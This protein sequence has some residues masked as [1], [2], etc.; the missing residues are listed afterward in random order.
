MTSLTAVGPAAAGQHGGVAFTTTHWSVVL[1]AQGESPA[2]QEALE[3]LCRIYWRPIYSFLRRQGISADDAQDLTQG[4]FAL[5]LERRDLRTVRKE[6]GRLRSYLLTAVKHFLADERRRAMAIKRGKGE[7]LIPLKELCGEERSGPEPADSLTAER[8][9]ER[10]W[11][12]TLLDRV[13]TRLE[14]TYGARGNAALFD[15]FNQLLADEPGAPSQ[16]D[17][18][19]QLGMTEN[20]VSQ[21]FHRFRQSYQSLL[22]EEIAHTVATPGDIENELRYLIA[23]IRA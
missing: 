11:A 2:A 9:Y 14:D 23:V 18:A 7:R 15:S 13:L 6:K 3:K 21:A 8:I 17:I 4:F 20:A 12:S 19:A 5:L 1:E 10:R 22:R 16:A